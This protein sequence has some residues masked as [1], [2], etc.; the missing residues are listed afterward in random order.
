M[1][2]AVWGTIH[3][4]R[5]LQLTVCLFFVLLFAPLFTE[6]KIIGGLAELTLL[7]SLV[8]AVGA[9]R[10]GRM[11]R[12]PLLG[13][14]LLA[15]TSFGVAVWLEPGAQGQA[16]II[17]CTILYSIYCFGCTAAVLAYVAE[18]RQGVTMDSLLASV[19]AYIMLSISFSCL[20]SLLILFDPNSFKPLIALNPAHPA[21]LYLTMIYFSLVTLTTVGYGA[22]APHSSFAQMFSGVEALIGQLYLAI[23]VAYLVGRT[24]S[25][26]FLEHKLQ[27]QPTGSSDDGVCIGAESERVDAE[28]SLDH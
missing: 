12:W 17:I 14:W 27:N 3:K 23:L 4:Y 8:V 25:A 11:M 10:T 20:F 24:L 9:S 28:A 5:F 6:Y 13:T 26:R 19:A 2:N 16:A 7:D 1:A 21:Q 15:I 18:N 22:I